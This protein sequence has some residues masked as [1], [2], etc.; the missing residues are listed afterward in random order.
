MNRGVFCQFSFRSNYYYSSN[1]FTG[2]GTGKMHLCAMSTWTKIQKLRD[3]R[4][5][6]VQK[7]EITNYKRKDKKLVDELNFF[8]R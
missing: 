7:K 3:I 4:K 5:S 1:E 6:L 8:T 2:K